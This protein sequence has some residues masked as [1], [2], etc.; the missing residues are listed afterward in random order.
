MDANK[1]RVLQKIEYRIQPCCGLCLHGQFAPA[2]DWGT[3]GVW[4]YQHLKHSADVRDLS[5]HRLGH[6]Q[7]FAP[8][9]KEVV[10][11]GAF[12]QFLKKGP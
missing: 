9:A 7:Q 11:L 5:I 3:C 2:T 4:T 12:S 1:L 6:C 8:A 10:Q